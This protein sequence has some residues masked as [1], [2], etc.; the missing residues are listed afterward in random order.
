MTT[1]NCNF[2]NNSNNKI[3]SETADYALGVPFPRKLDK[4]YAS[5]LILAHSIHYVKT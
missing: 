1:V 2:I 3:Q 5:S 4:T